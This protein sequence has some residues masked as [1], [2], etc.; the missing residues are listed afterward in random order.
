MQ[1]KKYLNEQGLDTQPLNMEDGSGL[2]PEI[3]LLQIY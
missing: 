2:S 1:I 3:T